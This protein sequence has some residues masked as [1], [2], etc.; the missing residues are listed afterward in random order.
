VL[1]TKKKRRM[2]VHALRYPSLRTQRAGFVPSWIM[3]RGTICYRAKRQDS[4]RWEFVVKFLWRSDKRRAEGGLL[5]LAK[6]RNV[7][8][9]AQLFGHQDLDRIDDLRQGMEFG[10]SRTF[11]LPT[12]NLFSESQS[13]ISDLLSGLGISKNLLS[14]SSSGQKRKRQSENIASG[15]PKRSRSNSR[16]YGGG[17]GPMPKYLFSTCQFPKITQMPI[18]TPLASARLDESTPK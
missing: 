2:I 4:K 15:Q 18:T 17:E 8:G 1:R 11:R 13:R 6:E 5:R 10:E 9:V 16:S 7:W 3:C 14:S 12:G